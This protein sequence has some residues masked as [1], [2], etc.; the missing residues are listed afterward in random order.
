M[1]WDNLCVESD[2]ELWW[3]HLVDTWIQS[4]T[5]EALI[6]LMAADRVRKQWEGE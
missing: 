2:W 6:M 1:C 4:K 3:D 5:D